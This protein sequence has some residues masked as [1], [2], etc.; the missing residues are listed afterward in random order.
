MR[1]NPRS[2]NGFY[3]R[4]EIVRLGIPSAAPPKILRVVNPRPSHFRRYRKRRSSSTEQI[5]SFG[6]CL[7]S[8]RNQQQAFRDGRAL[9]RRSFGGILGLLPGDGLIWG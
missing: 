5:L 3:F 1:P 2:K 6:S 8:K 4:G 9:Q 7:S